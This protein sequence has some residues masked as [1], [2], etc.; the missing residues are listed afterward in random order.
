MAEEYKEALAK[1]LG[2]EDW[3]DC[4]AKQKRY[5]LIDKDIPMPPRPGTLAYALERLP[6]LQEMEIGDSILDRGSQSCLAFNQTLPFG[7]SI[8][9]EARLELRYNSNTSDLRI[10]RTK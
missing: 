3:A 2:F 5:P 9:F 4:E 1:S 7:D 6:Q 8:E 10:W